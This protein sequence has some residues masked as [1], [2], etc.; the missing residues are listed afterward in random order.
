MAR[1]VEEAE[2]VAPAA[3]DEEGVQA[4]GAQDEERWGGGNEAEVEIAK[5]ARG[6]TVEGRL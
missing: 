1:A 6:G 5:V 3:G 2:A 4:V